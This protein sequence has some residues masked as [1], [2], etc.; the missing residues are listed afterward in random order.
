[1]SKVDRLRPIEF[2]ATPPEGREP[3]VRL[4]YADDKGAV[5]FVEVVK[6]KATEA[7]KSDYYLQTERTRLFAKVAASLGSRWSKTSGSAVK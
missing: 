5:G 3:V 2:T 1:M 6:T 7:G 4:E